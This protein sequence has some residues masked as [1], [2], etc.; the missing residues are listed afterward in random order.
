LFD[1]EVLPAD[2]GGA[3]F[4]SKTILLEFW[5]KGKRLFLP[6]PLKLLP[7]EGEEMKKPEAVLRASFPL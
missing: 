7:L 5:I 4:H 1:A 6:H 3:F 2:G